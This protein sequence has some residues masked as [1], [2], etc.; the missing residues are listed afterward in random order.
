[1]QR[2]KRTILSGAVAG[3]VAPLASAS[4]F[5]IAWH[6]IDGGVTRLG[7]PSYELVGTVGQCDAGPALLSSTYSIDGGF[8]PGL[9]ALPPVC[10]ADIDRDGQVGA[11]DLSILL[12]SWG[13]C[14]LGCPGDIDGDGTVSATDLANLLAAWGPC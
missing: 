12:G 2:I 10:P 11:S 8:Y 9:L 1:M 3:L 4:D 13:A 5:S 14:G 6:S 7:S